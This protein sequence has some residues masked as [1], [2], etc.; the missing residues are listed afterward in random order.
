MQKINKV[1]SKRCNRNVL[2]RQK[3][4]RIRGI[5]ILIL[6]FSLFIYGIHSCYIKFKCKDLQYAVEYYLTLGHS[7]ETLMTV[8]YITLTF[9]DDDS[10]IMDVSG[11]RKNKPHISTKLRATFK[12][13][14]GSS[15]KLDSVKKIENNS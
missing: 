13:T 5:L 7:D 12:K 1:N 14:R 3:Y 6:T 15:W 4:K 11:L 9:K 10:A 8:K 2:Q